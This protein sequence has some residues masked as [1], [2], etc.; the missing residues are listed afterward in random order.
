[1]KK[2]WR[3][4]LRPVKNRNY[5]QEAIKYAEEM[6]QSQVAFVLAPFYTLNAFFCGHFCEQ[7]HLCWIVREQQNCLSCARKMHLQLSKRSGPASVVLSPRSG[8]PTEPA[9]GCC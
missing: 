4:V 9:D 1:M 6:E 2:L 3:S 5:Q 7:F 8:S